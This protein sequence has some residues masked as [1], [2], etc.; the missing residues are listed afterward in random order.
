M[1]KMTSREMPCQSD[2]MTS[3]QL[4]E[5][6][7]YRDADRVNGFRMPDALSR[8]LILVSA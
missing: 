7:G 6:S 2:R 1:R 8:F 4:P 3:E 5:L